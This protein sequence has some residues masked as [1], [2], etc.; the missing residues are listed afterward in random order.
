MTYHD[1][2]SVPDSLTNDPLG[3]G[4]K[5][6]HVMSWCYLFCFQINFLKPCKITFMNLWVSVQVH[7]DSWMIYLNFFLFSFRNVFVY[8]SQK[9]AI[10]LHKLWKILNSGLYIFLCSRLYILN[11]LLW[12]DTQD[13]IFFTSSMLCQIIMYRL[14][15]RKCMQYLDFFE[16]VQVS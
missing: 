3:Q 13:L 6:D 4:R 14:L 10:R 9:K 7:Y 11:K 2:T 1:H 12:E 16:S 5:Y 15:Q 8:T